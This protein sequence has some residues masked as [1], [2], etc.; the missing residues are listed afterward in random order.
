MKRSVLLLL[1]VCIVCAQVNAASPPDLRTVA[2][3]TAWKSTSN[4]E[5]TLS[6]LREL[7]RLHPAFKLTRF[8]VSPQGRELPL[9]IVSRERAFTPNVARALPK[10][11]VLIQNGIHS[12]EI[13]GKDAMLQILREIATGHAK[14]LLD[15]ATL[16]VIPIYNV[17]GHERI[18]PY[19]RPNQDGPVDGMGYRTTTAGYDLNRDHL[20]LE[21]VEARALVALV[22]AWQPQLH[23]DNHVTDGSDLA[24]DVMF[25]WAEAPLLAPSLGA[26]QSTHLPPVFAAVAAAGHPWGPYVDLDDS[27]DPSKGFSSWVGQPR[28]S[29]SYFAMRNSISIL[30]ETHSHKPFQQRVAANRAFLEALLS[31]IARDPK[32]LIDAAQAARERTVDLGRA[33]AAPSDIAVVYA[34]EEHGEPYRLPLYRYSL[35]KSVVSGGDVLLYQSGE[36]HEIEVPWRHKPVVTQKLAR[37]RGYLVLPGWPQ[38]E[39]RLDGHGL[40]YSR[41]AQA[42]TVD[43]ETIRLGE[44]KFAERS[45][46]GRHGVSVDA[47]RTRETRH[48]PAGTLFINAD[49]PKFE[50]AVQ[51]LE[52]EAVDSLVSW[53]LLSSLFENKEWIN[54]FVLEAW[55]REQLKNPEIATAWQQALSDQGFASNGDARFSWW[56]QRHP[57]WDKEARLMPVMRLMTR[58]ATLV[59]PTASKPD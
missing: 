50:L 24:W 37:P 22:N 41:L 18:S 15:A 12:G 3:K 33:D 1:T 48:V 54:E 27:L 9:L 43:V 26:W 49:Q 58:P 55:A 59:A 17:D 19:N 34:G 23:V 2:E 10:P 16:L 42:E 25:S 56:Q 4:Y 35:E 21:T 47:L 39:A 52:P 6:F 51:L 31:E 30:V 36:V 46:Q 32:S 28:Y 20:K 53:G 7:C 5:E 45:Y 13:D 14:S 57:S 38:I 40:H 8:G 44:P 29:T 11:I